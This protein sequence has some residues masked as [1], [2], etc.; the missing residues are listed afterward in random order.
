VGQETHHQH[1][2]LKEITEVLLPALQYLAILGVA[3]A[4]AHL[5]L[6]IMGKQTAME[7]MELHLLYLVLAL[8]M[9]VEAAAV[10]EQAV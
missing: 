3:A 5:R 7:A 2:H 10:L 1:P 6:A 4:V 8:L 9:L